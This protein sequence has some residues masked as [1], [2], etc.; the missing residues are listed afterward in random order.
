MSEE[1]AV[2]QQTESA[3]TETNEVSRET[4]DI[5]APA[6]PEHIP[7]KFWN[8]ETGTP[9]VD[10]LAKSYNNLEKFSTG[11]KDEMREQLIA[12]ITAEASEG[13]PEDS[14]GYKLPPLVEGLTEEMVEENPL[15][16]WWREKCHSM[17]L[18]QDNFEDGIN[19]YIAFAQGQMPDTQKEIENLGENAQERIEAAN[20]WAS[21]VLNPEQFEVLQQTLGMS[22]R[23]IEVIESLM[24]ATKQNISRSANVAQPERE[25]NMSDVK[26]MMNDKRYYD[27]RYRDASYVKKVDD[28]FQRLQLSGKL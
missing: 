22:A 19:Q 20:S 17:G 15:T 28:A 9:N 6:R 21:T 1:Q 23:G 8:A 25:L 5:P 13:L 18:D 26:E 10:D 27:S 2:E 24:E 11:K 7:E 16:G 12:E 14:K 4:Q 3:Q